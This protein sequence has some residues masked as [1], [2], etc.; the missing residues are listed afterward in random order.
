MR[1]MP[2]AL[3]ELQARL[4]SLEEENRSL[5]SERDALA[6]ERDTVAAERD[7]LASECNVLREQ[8]VDLS[9]KVSSLEIRIERLL[10]KLYGRSSEK[11]SPDEILPGMLPFFSEEELAAL[12]DEHQ[13]PASELEPQLPDGTP[14]GDDTST[15]EGGPQEKRRKRPP[16]SLPPKNLPREVRDVT[17]PEEDRRCSACH[18]VM[19]SIGFETTEKI[20]R[21]PARYYVDVQQRHKYACPCK[22][23]SA[24][25]TRTE[26]GVVAGGIFG[27]SFVVDVAISKFLVHQPL[28]RQAM[29]L[30]RDHGIVVSSSTLADQIRHIADRL[31]PIYWAVIAELKR[32]GYLQADETPI[33]V[34]APEKCRQGW[35]WTYSNPKGPVVFEYRPG[36]G[37]DGPLEFLDGFVGAIQHDGYTVYDAVAL[38]LGLVQYGCWAHARRHF[39]EAREK[40][41]SRADRVI[42]LIQALYR[43]EAEAR[44]RGLDAEAR[45]ALREEKS[46]PVLSQLKQ[47]LDHLSG[48]LLPRHPLAQ[49]VEYVR[50]R[51][52]IL[53]RYV[54]DGRIEIDTNLAENSL[55]TVALLRNNSLFA[56]SDEGAVRAAIVLTLIGTV[57]RLGGNPREY[58]EW[59]LRESWDAPAERM[60]ELTPSRWLAGKCVIAE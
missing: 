16:R 22:Q 31:A 59:A 25:T 10:R 23:G 19:P 38:A 48:S 17:T 27:I 39:E 11:I 56:G 42:A 21:I 44:E 8:R 15:A 1:A 5:A 33:R 40:A 7:S 3:T 28:Y 29:L 6:T 26:P 58:L 60:L 18:E 24:I 49:A 45:R 55:R 2:D 20:E 47:V 51:W 4:R 9:D 52:E 53:T 34:L 36:R 30:R 37:R 46:R 54:D 41:K 35:I 32:L 13:I 50:K 43:V 12:E 57:L 14:G